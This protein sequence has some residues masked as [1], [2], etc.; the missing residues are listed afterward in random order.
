MTGLD[1]MSVGMEVNRIFAIMNNWIMVA[2]PMFIFM[3]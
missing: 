3:G 1:F 2:L